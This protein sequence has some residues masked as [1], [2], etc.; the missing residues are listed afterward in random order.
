MHVAC[1]EA[2][3]RLQEAPGKSL[4]DYLSLPV[5]DYNTLDPN[6]VQSLGDNRF[7][8]TPPFNDWFKIN[9]KPEVIL[10]IQPEPEQSRVRPQCTSTCPCG[11]C[12]PARSL[13]SSPS[14]HAT[15]ATLH[16]H[17]GTNMLSMRQA[18]CELHRE[19]HCLSVVKSAN[20]NCIHSLH[21]GCYSLSYSTSIVEGHLYSMQPQAA[22]QSSM[23]WCSWIVCMRTCLLTNSH[24]LGKGQAL[25]SVCTTQCNGFG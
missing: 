25:L 16:P 10:R 8:L 12:T 7:M 5:E 22:M 20:V 6:V 1:C 13:P 9:I 14:W 15:L 11:R 24:W 2:F 4:H 21:C 18:Q 3:K 23:H 19:L 17:V